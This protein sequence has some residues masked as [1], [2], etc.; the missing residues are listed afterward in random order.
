MGFHTHRPVTKGASFC[1]TWLARRQLQQIVQECRDA[2]GSW[3]H[4]L[5]LLFN[6]VTEEA[7]AVDCA[8]ML[9]QKGVQ[10]SEMP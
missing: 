10:I 7:T 2:E 9:P 5:T 1:G 8:C 4:S 6:S 3:M